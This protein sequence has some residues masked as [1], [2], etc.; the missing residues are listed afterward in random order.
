MAGYD[1]RVEVYYCKQNESPLPEH[2]IAPAPAISI[3][4]EIYYVNDNVTGYTYNI[5]LNGYANALRKDLDSDS[6]AYGLS[7]VISHMG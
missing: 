5:T 1:T 7:G 3:V 4:P 6:V 2:R